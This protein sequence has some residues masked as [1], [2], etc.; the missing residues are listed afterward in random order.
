MIQKTHL[1][2]YLLGKDTQGQSSI[3][4]DMLSSPGTVA[5]GTKGF[6]Q[7]PWIMSLKVCLTQAPFLLFLGTP[8]YPSYYLGMLLCWLFPCAPYISTP[9]GKSR[10]DSKIM[11]TLLSPKGLPLISHSPA[12]LRMSHSLTSFPTVF[13]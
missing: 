6:T 7:H 1:N 2:R 9:R 3:S 13:F 5:S 4:E 8:A 11:K 12:I 10:L